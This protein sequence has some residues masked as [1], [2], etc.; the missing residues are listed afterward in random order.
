MI[1]DLQSLIFRNRFRARHARCG[2]S[3]CWKPRTLNWI[4][5]LGILAIWVNL[6]Q[7]HGN[8]GHLA[9]LARRLTL[10]ARLLAISLPPPPLPQKIARQVGHDCKIA[11]QTCSNKCSTF[12]L[13]VVSC[14][15]GFLGSVVSV[16]TCPFG[17]RQPLTRGGQ[18]LK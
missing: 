5:N 9:P 11:W 7:K 16:A 18:F 8:L 15:T 12:L 10:S 13:T 1:Q 14:G 6:G 4:A 17:L 3:L 2:F